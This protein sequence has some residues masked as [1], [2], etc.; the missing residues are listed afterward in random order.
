MN[1]WN[2]VERPEI[3]KEVE[4]LLDNG[5]V[6]KDMMIKGKYGTYEWRNWVDRHVKAW[7]YIEKAN[8]NE[9]NKK[10]TNTMKKN[11]RENRVATM[12][13]A[14]INTKKY[15]S[16]NLPEGLKP[17]SVISLVID[18]DGNPAITTDTEN[19]FKYERRIS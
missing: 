16:I 1:N 19:K 6:G 18:E 9:L 5:T 8:N 11:N 2:Y 7:R 17:G 12:Q 15:F 14:G 13:A 4:I 3:Y 10:E